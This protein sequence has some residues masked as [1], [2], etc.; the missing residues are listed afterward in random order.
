M[1]ANERLS[2]LIETKTVGSASVDALSASLNKVVDIADKA[3]K[4]LGEAP[5]NPYE[6]IPAQIKQFVES[7]MQS[8]TSAIAGLSK[9]FGVVGVAA[10]SVVSGLVSILAASESATRSLASLGT[11]IQNIALRTGLSTK[12]VGQFG[13]AAQ[14]VG[15]DVGVL[16]TAMRKLSQGIADGS[17]EGKK[18]RAGLKALGV[19][20]MDING[21]LKP[22]SDILL[23]VSNGLQGV[24]EAAKR[25]KVLID[26]FGRSGIE[27]IPLFQSLTANVARAKELGFGLDQQTVDRYTKYEEQIAEIDKRWSGLARKMKD[28]IA[29]TIW[30][31]IQN[32]VISALSPTTSNQ[33]DRYMAQRF[34]QGVRPDSPA[35]AGSV[36]GPEVDATDTAARLAAGAGI[37]G[38]DRKRYGNTVTGATFEAAEAKTAADK[39]RTVYFSME[40]QA[41]DAA[42]QAKKKE[43]DSAEAS[44]RKLEER[45]KL[46]TKEE[47]KRLSVLEFIADLYRTPVAVLEKQAEMKAKKEGFYTIGS[48]KDTAIVSKAD[49]SAANAQKGAFTQGIERSVNSIN[50]QFG[51]D[52][53][54]NASFDL[55]PGFDHQASLLDRSL[56][57]KFKAG[58]A[59]I[60]TQLQ[61][62]TEKAVVRFLGGDAKGFGLAVES[63]EKMA[64]K[65]MERLSVRTSG[66]FSG[67]SLVV[68][69][70]AI[71][72][73]NSA[74]GAAASKR[75]ELDF[76]YTGKQGQ[77]RLAIAQ[78]V[79]ATQERIFML[80]AA[81]GGEF[82]AAEKSAKLRLHVAEME[83]ESS[84]DLLKFEET[85]TQ[86][87]LDREV[88][89]TELQKKRED[90]FKSLVGGL[91]GAVISGNPSSAIPS[92]LTGTGRSIATT[93]AT[94]GAD[95]FA[96]QAVSL[97]P[98]ASDPNS[99]FGKLLANTPF[100]ADPVKTATDLNTAATIANTQ[101]LLTAFAGLGAAS[102]GSTGGGY[103]A[104]LGQFAKLAGITLPSGGGAASSQGAF[105][106]Q[107]SEDGAPI[108]D[109]GPSAVGS[110]SAG[111]DAAG[112]NYGGKI[113]AGAAIA[114]GAATA[115]NGF[116][117]GGARGALQG[118]S[119]ALAA[120]GGIAALIPGGQMVAIGLE[121]AALVTGMIGTFLPDPKKARENQI[122]KELT[123]GQYLAPVAI[124]EKRDSGGN[125]VDYDKF[126]H[127][128]TSPFSASPQISEPYLHYRDGQYLNVPGGE[129]S[130][131]ST[132]RPAA[133][134]NVTIQAVDAK[135]FSD[136]AMKNKHSLGDAVASHLSGGDTK[137]ASQIG[138]LTGTR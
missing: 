64:N 99:T 123:Q 56:D 19:S 43:W 82:D 100:A 22:T 105:T 36:Y 88:R 31:D 75:G 107:L 131:F 69:S 137:L 79:A 15:M 95:M 120:A 66:A 70:A 126:G 67:G 11:G 32:G 116:S 9:G 103:S 130:P 62:D 6:A 128:R 34:G 37:V 110:S 42:V 18:S 61:L 41:G 84:G 28:G 71:E 91:F 35:F 33:R 14:A 76:D 86:I 65:R 21:N 127:L 108:Y 101:A 133:T 112:R 3:G 46:L 98:K 129:T 10:V 77:S 52:F 115:Y 135:S 117:R 113:A 87:A 25:N 138:Y 44:A 92:F 121:A 94:N 47:S 40:G 57:E 132:T 59:E 7:P 80:T 78:Q 68:D 45:V 90:E 124:N 50:S 38:G 1:P 27:L 73:A 81:P 55:K 136:L 74:S 16:E 63:A 17:E 49:I 125:Y 58:R 97:I 96:K 30:I 13:F 83:L 104:A 114:G 51:G 2:L 4:K 12:E 119:G 24:G 8:A 109:G 122:N 48:G 29:G 60:L 93:I 72:G 102:G 111:D 85:R 54:A 118:S 89:V 39:L 106:G 53:M 26:V 5:K 23:Q 20:Y 134:M